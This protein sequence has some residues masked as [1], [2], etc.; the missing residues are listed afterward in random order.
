MGRKKHMQKSARSKVFLRLTS[1]TKK[2]KIIK[3]GF[4][5]IIGLMD[6]SYSIVVT[7]TYDSWGKIVNI[8]DESENNIGYI[9]PYRYRSYYYDNETNLYYL[10]NR[11]YNPVWCRF[12]N[13]DIYLDNEQGF[14]STNMYNYTENNPVSRT[15]KDGEL[16]FTA[17]FTIAMTLS[18]GVIKAGLKVADNIINKK[19]LK[20]GVFKEFT[21]GAVSGFISSLN[22]GSVVAA[23][24]TVVGD[25]AVDY[26]FEGKID[27]DNVVDALTDATV[28]SIVSKIPA[29]RPGR[30]PTR[31]KTAF[32]G[33]IGLNTDSYNLVSGTITNT[34][35]KTKTTVVPYTK[36][37]I[38]KVSKSVKKF[39]SKVVNKIKS[40][41]KW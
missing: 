35:N 26:A 31:L 33:K 21:Y 24:L 39:V 1:R 14:Y 2:E 8:L 16:F 36:T 17:S 34:I 19:D 15:D 5:D 40:W 37:I 7:Y 18:G 27:Q 9:N 11:Y 22:V 20:D 13:A 38:E 3:N 23:G 4:N 41:F 32:L 30:K 12:I 28:S 6:D 10:N 29:K 25:L